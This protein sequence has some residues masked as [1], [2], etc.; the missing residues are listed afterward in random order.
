MVKGA[1]LLKSDEELYSAFGTNEDKLKRQTGIGNIFKWTP[2][3]PPNLEGKHDI[4]RIL[5][6][7]DE[8]GNHAV[9]YKV[10]N[11]QFRGGS[12]N[13]MTIELY[14]SSGVPRQA[15]CPPTLFS[16]LAVAM[17]D[18]GLG[19]NDVAGKVFEIWQKFLTSA[20][21]SKRRGDK[22]YIQCPMCKGTKVYQGSDCSF[23][24]VTGTKE[25]SGKVTGH[26]PLL[27][28]DAALRKDLMETSEK[29]AIIEEF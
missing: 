27:V 28:F 15:S 17:K 24:T 2:P 12:A 11:P 14:E 22:G 1:I 3:V 26:K 23:C 10:P 19:I 29:N 25:D 4:V 7:E 13:F 8:S 21:D 16:R 5:Y 18:E 20:P 9:F 6:T